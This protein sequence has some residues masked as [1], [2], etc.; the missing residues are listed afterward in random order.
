MAGPTRIKGKQL[1]LKLDD[2]DYNCNFTKLFMTNEDAD[3]GDN[4]VTFC[5]AESGSKQWFF[6][7][8][9]LQ[10][11]D[12]DSFWTFLWTAYDGSTTTGIDFVYAP[13]GNATASATQPHFVGTVNLTGRPSI[14][15][16]AGPQD[17]T[18]DYRIDING[19]PLRVI[20]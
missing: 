19:E 12:A 8:T 7:A 20:A 2:T 10:S 4:A 14:G 13:H 15:G 1:T 5:D 17:Q 16:E 3:S 11:T 9:A 18:F 6:E